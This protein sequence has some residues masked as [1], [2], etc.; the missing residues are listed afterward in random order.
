[1]LVRGVMGGVRV[2]VGRAACVLALARRLAGARCTCPISGLW[3]AQQGASASPAG[4]DVAAL[5]LRDSC[6]AHVPGDARALR[7]VRG[8]RY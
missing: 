2:R 7:G 1:M 4:P 5:R 3:C 6:Q 8:G